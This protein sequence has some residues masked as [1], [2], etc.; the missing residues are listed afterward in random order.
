MV[1]AVTSAAK[2]ITLLQVE[3]GIFV[4]QAVEDICFILQRILERALR[5]GSDMSVMAVGNR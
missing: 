4:L 3:E 2:D 1:K 5:C